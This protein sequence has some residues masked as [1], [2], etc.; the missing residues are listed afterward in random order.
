MEQARSLYNMG[1]ALGDG[2]KLMEAEAAHRQA[3]AIRAH[4]A[5]DHPQEAVYRQD[6]SYSHCELA[7][8]LA[9]RNK[10]DASAEEFRQAVAVTQQLS[11]EHPEQPAYWND[12]LG[13]LDNFIRV[14]QATGQDREAK[15]CEKRMAE[16]KEKLSK[17]GTK[18]G[19]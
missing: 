8:V 5:R 4:L 16:L 10:L 11:K 7:I 6:L 12:E 9:K 18:P 19:G 3:L 2:P 14:L 17:A 13:H 15:Q 1:I